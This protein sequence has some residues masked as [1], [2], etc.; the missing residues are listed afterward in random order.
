VSPNTVKSQLKSIYQ[1][2]GASTREEAVARGRDLGL[3]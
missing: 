3:L 1:K 2:L